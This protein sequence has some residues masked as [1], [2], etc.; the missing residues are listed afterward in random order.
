M[1]IKLYGSNLCPKTLHAL[2]VMDEA[3]FTPTFINVTG[4][5]NLL[6]DWVEFRD[7]NPLFEELRGTR[8]VGFPTFQLEDGT[9]TRDLDYVMSLIKAENK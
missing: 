5:I 4:S 1:T 9:Y 2:R 6:M 7:T 3:G 8:K